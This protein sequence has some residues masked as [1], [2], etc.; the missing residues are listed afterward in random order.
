MRNI[1]L[2]DTLD[3]PAREVFETAAYDLE[4]LARVMPDVTAVLP[5][6]TDRPSAKEQL[7]TDAWHGKARG[8]S[9]Q[10]LLDLSTARWEVDSR[11]RA[12]NLR[13]DWDI[14]V[15]EPKKAVS[16]QGYIAMVAD[17]PEQTRVE[18]VGELS[19]HPGA[20]GRAM[21]LMG[22]ALSPLVEQTLVG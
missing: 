22:A 14:R 15:L 12:D 6:V 16:A 4:C 11:W 18:M 13:V 9:L 1:R 7:R 8:Q 2:D 5:L 17:G 10:K 21:A 19:F 20:L 3:F